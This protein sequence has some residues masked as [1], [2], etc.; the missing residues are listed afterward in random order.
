[1][2]RR[3][4]WKQGF[5]RYAGRSEKPGLWKG[6]LGAW[7][8][9]L[10]PTGATLY[11]V[12]QYRHHGTLDAG[13][14]I[15]A[16][17]VVSDNRALPGY[18]LDFSGSNSHVDCGNFVDLAGQL[19]LAAWVRLS[20]NGNFVGIIARSTAFAVQNPNLKYILGLN[21]TSRELWFSSANVEADATGQVVPI[22]AWHFVGL[23]LDGANGIYYL[24]QTQSTFGWSGTPP[25]YA[26]TWPLRIGSFTATNG[27]LF[28][29]VG[30]AWTYG[31]ALTPTEMGVLATDPGAMVRLEELP[32]GIVPAADTSAAEQPVSVFPDRVGGPRRAIPYW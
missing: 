17:W 8:P 10:G 7:L 26:G 2:L 21:S 6:L 12:S 24:D 13:M 19:T 32:M 18:A 16:D 14:D 3:P 15:S 20:A 4:S 11:D 9:S 1:M 5:A 23:T 28:G 25:T 30:A 22:G 31:R 27:E 29:Q